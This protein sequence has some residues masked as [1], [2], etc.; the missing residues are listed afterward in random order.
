MLEPDKNL[1]PDKIK[2]IHLT[3]ICGT[4]MGALAAMLK[5]LGYVVTG[6]DINIYPPVSD[7]LSSKKI[8]IKKEFKPDNLFYKP[9]LVIIGNAISANNPEIFYIKKAGLNYCSMP[10]AI[11]WFACLNKKIL[12]ITGT[13][14]K[15]TISSI[16]ASILYNAGLDPSFIIGGILKNFNASYKIGRGEYIILEGD[17]YDTAFFDKG[18]KFLHYIPQIAILSSIEFDHADIYQNIDHIKNL[19]KYCLTICRKTVHFLHTI[20][21]NRLIQL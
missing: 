5:E 4:G 2:S 7:F 14:G 20:M 18:P 6:S 9:D 11:N 3:A 12:L 17:E 1:I 19:L 16:L 15:T 13:H 10:Q 8:E 21:I